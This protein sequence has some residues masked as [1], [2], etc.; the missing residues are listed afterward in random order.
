MNGPASWLAGL[1]PDAVL[2]DALA[3]RPGLP[4]R[5][6]RIMDEKMEDGQLSESP[7][8]LGEI[9]KVRQAFLDSLI[10]HYHQRIAYPNFPGS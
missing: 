4:T 3:L 6:D 5:V 8:T 9:T 7:L 2:A 1:A 10:G